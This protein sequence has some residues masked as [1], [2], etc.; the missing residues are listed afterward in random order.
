MRNIFGHVIPLAEYYGYIKSHSYSPS[1][2][3]DT[4]ILILTNQITA[5]PFD[6]ARLLWRLI[7]H[8]MHVACAEHGEE[9]REQPSRR[10]TWFTVALGC[11]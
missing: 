7:I 11:F 9:M 2:A 3:R 5:E 4:A 6:P 1:P 8:D 10:R